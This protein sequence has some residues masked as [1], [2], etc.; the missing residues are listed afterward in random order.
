MNSPLYIVKWRQTPPLR[1]CWA[2]A[3]DGPSDGR[4]ISS[5]CNGCCCCCWFTLSAM[6]TITSLRTRSLL[7]PPSPTEISWSPRFVGAPLLTL[8]G[9]F[10]KRGSGSDVCRLRTRSLADSNPQQFVDHYIYNIIVYEL[11][12]AFPTRGILIPPRGIAEFRR[13]IWTRDWQTQTVGIVGVKWRH[14]K[15]CLCGRVVSS[16]GRHVQ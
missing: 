3:C 1:S 9:S 7:S 6:A 5:C 10:S 15:T 14:S 8:V 13:G 2:V 16:L 11:L 12:H 4:S